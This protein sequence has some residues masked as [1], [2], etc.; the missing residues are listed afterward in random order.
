LTRQR[1]VSMFGLSVIKTTF[2]EATLDDFA[3]EQVFQRVLQ[4]EL[5]PGVQPTLG[6]L[7]DS[8]GTILRYSLDG[9]GMSL[10]ELRAIQDWVVVPALRAVP[11]VAD[12]NAFGGGSKQWRVVADPTL[13][14]SHDVTL[15][16]VQQALAA[17][18]VNGGGSVI[19]RG[20]QEYTV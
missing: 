11:G 10:Y 6:P 2:D 17:G 1:S 18:N 20:G 3:R 9:P 13:L 15:V 16:Q 8:T 19:A 12:V 5:P 4:A 7:S 14:R